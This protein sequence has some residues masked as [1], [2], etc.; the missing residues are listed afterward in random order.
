[1]GLR[2]SHLWQVAFKT[3]VFEPVLVWGVY[4]PPPFSAVLRR[5]LFFPGGGGGLTS[6]NDPPQEK[7]SRTLVGSNPSPHA[8]GVRILAAVQLV[9]TRA[10]VK[11]F[12]SG[13][14]PPPVSLAPESDFRPPQMEQ[15]VSVYGQPKQEH[16]QQKDT[17]GIQSNN[18]WV[19][20]PAIVCLRIV[21][22]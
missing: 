6:K 14:Q 12:D 18:G 13:G 5:P 11:A 20:L 17:A 8:R 16:H 4:P 1:M 22:I 10:G 19:H 3:P 15:R 2:K 9:E 7:K 21:T